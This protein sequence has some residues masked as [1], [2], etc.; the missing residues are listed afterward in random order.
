MR[1]AVDS[2]EW[3]Q[4]LT[5]VLSTEN[6]LRESLVRVVLNPDDNLYRCLNNPYLNQ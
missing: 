4:E 2:Y 6:F 3:Y 1:I 5:V